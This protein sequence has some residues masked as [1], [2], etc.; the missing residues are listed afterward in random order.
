MEQ[1]KAL[2]GKDTQENLFADLVP[3]AKMV[4]RQLMHNS[5]D[6]KLRRS[7]AVDIIEAAG[8][9]ADRGQMMLPP[10]MIKDSQVALLL[11]GAREIQEFQEEVPNEQGS[12]D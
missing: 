9:K 8:A 11:A 6:S 5:S 2:T 3:E 12:E 1:G 7:T 4:L 10:I